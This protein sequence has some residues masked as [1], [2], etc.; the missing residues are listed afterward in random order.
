MGAIA[1]F[2]AAD[3]DRLDA[4]FARGDRDPAAYEEFRR[5]L[6]KH[7]GMEELVLLPAVKR[8]TGKP[9]AL[10][11]KIRLE[12]GALTSL[13]IPTPTPEVLAAVRAILVPHNE[14]EE[15]LGGLYDECEAVLGAEAEKILQDLRHAR[16]IPPAAHA[17]GEHVMASVRRAIAA[18]GFP[19]LL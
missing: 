10:A 17:D 15:K 14:L 18:A 12:H 1:D 2:L 3:H 7:V 8:L 11:E 19:P 4:L 6:L 13:M 9:A 16:A 5:G